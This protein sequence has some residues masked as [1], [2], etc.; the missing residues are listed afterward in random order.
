MMRE[1]AVVIIHIIVDDGDG[2]WSSA[3][4]GVFIEIIVARTC[5]SSIVIGNCGGKIGLVC[6]RRPYI[7]RLD[8]H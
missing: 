7:L 5:I 2:L 3:L 6:G 4:Y 1:V 8:F